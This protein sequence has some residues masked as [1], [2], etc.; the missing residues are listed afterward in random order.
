[1]GQ[2]ASKGKDKVR[3]K[4]FLSSCFS[5]SECFSI[6]SA[7]SINAVETKSLNCFKG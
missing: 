4:I 6:I 7:A 3:G 5:S 2:E 1:M